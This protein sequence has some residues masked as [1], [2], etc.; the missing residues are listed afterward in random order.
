MDWDKLPLAPEELFGANLDILPTDGGPFQS[1]ILP[2]REL[3]V[4]PQMVSPLYLKRE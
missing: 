3:V 1:I 4:Y 2:L